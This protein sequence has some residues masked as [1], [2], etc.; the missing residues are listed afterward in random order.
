[1]SDYRPIIGITMGDPVG[2][3][4]EIIL[5]SLC[6]P[7]IYNVCRPLVIGDIQILDAVKKCVR[8]TLHIKSVKDPEEGIYKFGSIDLLNLSEIV[9]DKVLWGNPTVET[10][11]AM[12]RYIKAAADLATKG[13]IAAMVTC[14]INKA[15]IRMAGCHYNGHTELL[16]ERTGSKFFAMMLAGNRLRVVL[17]TIHV[18]FKEVPSL[19]SEE[20]VLL[21]IKL[22]WQ[23]LQERFGLK[24]PRIAVAGLNPH[25]GEGGIFGDEEKTIITPAIH[26]ARNQ[27]F[28]VTG[29]LP[30]DTVFHQAANGRYDA[31]V[32]MYHDQGLIPFKLIHFNDGVNITLGLP[33]IRTSVD[34]G[35]AYDIAGTGTA[36]PG[37]LIA[38]ITMA[39]QQAVYAKNKQ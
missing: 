25:A 15:A 16:A 3:G 39:A 9:P 20:K 37:S 33:I 23:T 8:S 27:G 10:G 5:L 38:A 30:P 31:V 18:P 34:H 32:S 21:T 17:V 13:R 36:N 28:D 14:P 6:K 35:T 24:T 1:M 4:P 22:T 11:R 12:I 19:L 26:A 7:S 2:I 29:A